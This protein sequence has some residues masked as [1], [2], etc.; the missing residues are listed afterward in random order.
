MGTDPDAQTVHRRKIHLAHVKMT[1]G[2]WILLLD[3][4]LF[5]LI[6]ATGPSNGLESKKKSILGPLKAISWMSTQF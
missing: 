1:K 6:Q 5:A 2:A 3:G 4:R